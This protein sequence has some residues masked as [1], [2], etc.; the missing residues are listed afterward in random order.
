MGS[1]QP[2]WLACRTGRDALIQAIAFVVRHDAPNYTGRLDEYQILEVFARGSCGRYGTS[3]DYL[4]NTVRGLHDHGIADPHLE[5]LARRAQAR[6]AS[7][8]S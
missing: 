5:R 8:P 3:L 1:Y 7:R 2:R 6:T 4:V